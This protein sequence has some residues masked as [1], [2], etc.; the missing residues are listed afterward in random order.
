MPDRELAGPAEERQ[1]ERAQQHRNDDKNEHGAPFEPVG[2]GANHGAE[3]GHRQ[4]PQH[5]QHRDD[6]GRPGLLIREYRDGEHLQPANREDDEADKPE[7]A[8]IG[9]AKE[10]CSR[11]GLEGSDGHGVPLADLLKASRLTVSISPPM[12]LFSAEC[13]PTA[14]VSRTRGVDCN[15]AMHRGP[16]IVKRSASWECAVLKHRRCGGVAAKWLKG[17][18]GSPADPLGRLPSRPKLNSSFL[19]GPPIYPN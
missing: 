9:F 17:A 7:A 12:L 6:E 1:D 3:E 8:K 11:R 19:L 5:R 13:K 10:P 16:A 14:S 15:S 2:H 18:R 4:H